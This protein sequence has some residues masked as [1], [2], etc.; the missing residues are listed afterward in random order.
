MRDAFPREITRLDNKEPCEAGPSRVQEKKFTFAAEVEDTKGMTLR[1]IELKR[2]IMLL[3]KK[4]TDQEPKV[5]KG[6]QNSKRFETRCYNC[7]KLGHIAR[8]CKK[9]QGD[10]PNLGPKSKCSRQANQQGKAGWD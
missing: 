3:E 4:L 2:W 6:G 5:R 8:N 1:E 7:G 10:N 9:G